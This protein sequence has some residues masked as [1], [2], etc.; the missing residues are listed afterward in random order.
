[1]LTFYLLRTITSDP[2]ALNVPNLSMAFDIA[3]FVINPDL[4]F[5]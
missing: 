4:I 3:E 2:T 5:L 1:M